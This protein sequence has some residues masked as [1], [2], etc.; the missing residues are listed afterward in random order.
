MGF[1]CCCGQL[2]QFHR[3]GSPATLRQSQELHWSPSRHTQL[4]PTDAYGTLEF[5]GGAHPT[6]AQVRC[7]SYCFYF[8]MC[9]FYWLFYYFILFYCYFL[10]SFIASYFIR[11]TLIL[12]AKLHLMYQCLLLYSCVNIIIQHSLLVDKHIILILWDTYC[13]VLKNEIS[14]VTYECVHDVCKDII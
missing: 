8:V 4:Q 11:I 2:W 7:L 1:R 5:Q 10:R 13:N 9:I 6:K 3:D 12:Q 14:N